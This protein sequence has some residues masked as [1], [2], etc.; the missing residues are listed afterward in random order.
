MENLVLLGHEVSQDLKELLD[1][2]DKRVSVEKANQDPEARRDPPDPLD[3]ETV[4]AQRLLTWRAQDSRIW[5]KSGVFMVSQ[6]PQGLRALLESPVHRWHWELTARLPLDLLDHLDWM[7]LLVYRGRTVRPASL[8]NL[9]SEG[10]RETVVSLVFQEQLERRVLKATQ[11]NQERQDKPGWRDF[12]VPWDQW[13]LQDP[14]AHRG[15]RTAAIRVTVTTTTPTTV[16]LDSGARL[17]HRVHR[18]SPAFRAGRVCQEAMETKGRR[19]PEVPKA[20]QA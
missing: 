14:P 7:E 11:D 20:S 15:P 17:D 6:A 9:D 16:R 8:V 19:D 13:D 4:T 2:A 18:A 3:L 1:P 10:R 12:Q 5:T